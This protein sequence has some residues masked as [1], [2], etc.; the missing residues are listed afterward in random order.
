MKIILYNLIIK[1]YDYPYYKIINILLQITK[2]QI[3]LHKLKIYKLKPSI[4]FYF[5]L[6]YN[7]TTFIYK[8]KDF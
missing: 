2:I 6:I 5:L 3:L 1:E 8:K 7:Q 4:F